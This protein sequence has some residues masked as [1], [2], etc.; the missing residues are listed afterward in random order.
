METCQSEIPLAKLFFN[1][2]A[3]LLLMEILMTT[4]P[5]AKSILSDKTANNWNLSFAGEF[6]NDVVKCYLTAQET[7]PDEEEDGVSAIAPSQSA[8]LSCTFKGQTWKLR[9]GFASHHTRAQHTEGQCLKKNVEHVYF[10]KIS[11]ISTNQL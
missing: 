1:D 8:S 6:G 11:W 4:G 2:S 9:L 3:I 5:D 7:A 10:S